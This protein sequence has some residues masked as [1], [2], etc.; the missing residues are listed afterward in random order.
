MR[1][2]FQAHINELLEK[3]RA[4]RDQLGETQARMAAVTATATS[5]DGLVRV[6]VGPR[7]ELVDLKLHPHVYRAPDA[8]RLAASILAT[9]REAGVQAQHKMMEILRPTLP[10]ELGELGA[11]GTDFD[12]TT[13]LPENPAAAARVP[14]PP[15]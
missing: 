12:V 11:M 1:P 9:T 10:A 5:P 8:E 14:R 2:E 6:T 15:R 3:Y 13:F 4:M 7:G